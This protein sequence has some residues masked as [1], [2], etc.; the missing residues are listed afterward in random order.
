LVEEWRG[1]GRG[2]ECRR[3]RRNK[4]EEEEEPSCPV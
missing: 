1:E 2:G 4:R 3:R